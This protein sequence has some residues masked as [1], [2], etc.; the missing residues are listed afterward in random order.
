MVVNHR[1]YL[2]NLQQYLTENFPGCFIMPTYEG[3]KIPM[4][5][6]KKYTAEEFLRRGCNIC[7]K[8]AVICLRRELFVVDI[9]EHDYAHD[10]EDKFP[11]FKETVSTQTKKGRHYY[12]R[13]IDTMKH[14]T[15]GARKLGDR[16]IPIDFKT[17]TS[18]GT[19]GLISIPPSPDK[20]WM[21]G[22]ELGKAEVLHIPQEFVDFILP[23]ME[24]NIPVAPRSTAPA[25]TKQVTKSI[26]PIPFDTLRTCVMILTDDFYGHRTYDRWLLVVFLIIHISLQNGYFDDGVELCHD[27]AEQ[28]G[29]YDFDVLEDKIQEALK[30]CDNPVGFGTLCYFVFVDYVKTMIKLI[31]ERARNNN[32]MICLSLARLCEVKKKPIFKTIWTSMCNGSDDDMGRALMSESRHKHGDYTIMKLLSTVN[33]DGAANVRNRWTDVV[34]G[35]IGE[36]KEP[37]PPPTLHEPG[38]VFDEDYNEPKM[39]P[40]RLM[41]DEGCFVD[42]INVVVAHMGIGKTEMMQVSFEKLPTCCRILLICPS[43]ALCKSIHEKLVHLGFELY[44]ETAESVVGEDGDCVSTNS[45]TTTC[46]YEDDSSRLPKL[47]HD[48][49]LAFNRIVICVD[50]LHRIDIPFF[51]V[52]CIDE[53]TSVLQRFQTEMMKKKVMVCRSFQKIMYGSTSI[54]LMDANGDNQLV[55]RFVDQLHI[56]RMRCR[57]E[58]AVVPVDDDG[59]WDL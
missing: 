40:I 55:R 2:V 44:N 19:G 24:T 48:Y 23:L 58:R 28:G 30:P 20:S 37:A 17:E 54:V 6:Q 16:T 21:L 45:L 50:S 8:G 57:E 4:G 27:F 11:A 38:R 46:P 59:G 14:I 22:R 42:R 32:F 53:V 33:P 13:R 34:H 56:E 26:S 1:E 12:F 39:R 49:Y 5:S 51:D 52:V 15:D 7:S 25:P 9:D 10:I 47:K 18:T 29:S 41:D 3:G 43:V 36:P 35:M 31:P